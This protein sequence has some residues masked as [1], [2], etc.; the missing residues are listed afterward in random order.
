MRSG[1]ASIAFKALQ[2]HLAGAGD[3]AGRRTVRQWRATGVVNGSSAVI[4]VVDD[5]VVGL[6]VLGMRGGK[7]A[8]A[9]GM[10]SPKRLGRLTAVWSEQ[11][12]GAPI[13]E[14]W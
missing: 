6:L 7:I 5:R 1:S 10:A 2:R 4:A 11:E 3:D 13:I 9:H 14:S 12:H 8:F